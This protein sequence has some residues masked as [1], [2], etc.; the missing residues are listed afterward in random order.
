MISG[1]KYLCISGVPPPFSVL[2]DEAKAMARHCSVGV[3][4]RMCAERFILLDT[5]VNQIGVYVKYEQ[6]AHPT[7]IF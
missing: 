4:L 3:E 1:F 6:Y 2:S 5:Q 7:I